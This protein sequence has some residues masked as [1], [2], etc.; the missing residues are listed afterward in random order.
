M[1]DYGSVA[2]GDHADLVK[3]AGG[4]GSDEHGHPFVEVFDSDRM[5]ES[6]EDGLVIDTSRWAVSAMNGRSTCPKL[7]RTDES[8]KL[9]CRYWPPE[10]SRLSIRD[11]RRGRDPRPP[12][13]SGMVPVVLAQ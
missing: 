11:R 6:V 7:P 8:R 13:P 4:V 9:T 10:G 12:V 5:V 1:D 3:V 2:R